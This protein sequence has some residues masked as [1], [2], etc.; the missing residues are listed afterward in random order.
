MKYQ[1]DKNREQIYDEELLKQNIYRPVAP[2]IQ[3]EEGESSTA[4]FVVPSKGID[5]ATGREILVKKDGSLT[6]KYDPN[7][8]VGMGN[9]IAKVELG[10][11]T[12]FYWK[13]FSISAGM[14]ITCGGWI[15]NATRAGKVEGI[16]I[17]GNVDRRAFTERWHQVDDKVYYIGYDPKFPAANQTERFLEKRNEFY[18]SSLGFAYE[19]KPEWVR[20]IWL[21]RLRIGVNF[22]DVLRLS[23]VKFER[24]TSYPY[25]RGFNFTISPTF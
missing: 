14:S 21:K 17:S 9:S 1:N 12:S 7:D 25:M 20:H 8:K 16:D 13:G 22:S 6:F 15:Y 10:L 24:G 5:P 19:F 23:T 11:G 3:F 18:L 4:I 2:K